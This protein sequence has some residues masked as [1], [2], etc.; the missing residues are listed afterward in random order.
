MPGV[1]AQGY[2]SSFDYEKNMALDPSFFA[3]DD[4][5]MAFG[6]TLDDFVTDVST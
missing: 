4:D 6:S 3:F 2:L 5:M 1:A